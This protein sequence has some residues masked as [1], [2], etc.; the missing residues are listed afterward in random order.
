VS[1]LLLASLT[2]IAHLIA[3]VAVTPT[4]APKAHR[5]APTK[6]ST[7]SLIRRVSPQST[8]IM[9]P[10]PAHNVAN[11]GLRKSRRQAR[12]EPS[13]QRPPIYAKLPD[14]PLNQNDISFADYFINVDKI[15]TTIDPENNTPL[16]AIFVTGLA[17]RDQQDA[18]VDELEKKG[19]SKVLGN[20]QVEMKCNWE[21]LKTV[22]KTV[23][24]LTELEKERSHKKGKK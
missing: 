1:Q 10:K 14:Q 7:T 8:P 3:I 2:H 9:D 24:L 23:G 22:L 19:M 5:A 12:Q 6:A 16:V 20:G 4:P 17:E 18:I 13:P 15:S 21:D 11:T